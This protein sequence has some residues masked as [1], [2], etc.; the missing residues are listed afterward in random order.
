MESTDRATDT[1]RAYSWFPMIGRIIEIA[2]PG[3]HL[4]K[5]R[6]SLSVEAPTQP[7]QTIPLDTLDAVILHN[8]T[9]LSVASINA[10]LDVGAIVVFCNDKYYPAALAFPFEGH[11]IQAE[12]MRLQLSASQPLRKRLWQAIVQEKI[13][14]QSAL[15]ERTVQS[16]A[17]RSFPGRVQ[18]GDSEN[19]EAQAAR[20]YWRELFGPDFRRGRF[21]D[22]E[23]SLLNYGYAVL[24]ATTARAVASSGLHPSFALHHRD[25]R[26]AMALVDDIM[27][28]Y[29]PT[30]DL[31][32]HDISRQGRGLDSEAKA[33]LASIIVTDIHTDTGLSPLRNCVLRTAS[34]LIKAFERKEPDIWYPTS[35]LS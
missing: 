28:P 11:H 25:A 1:A 9:T 5:I 27:E 15:L 17:L 7:A 4:R 34:S 16:H 6:G 24:R 33:A 32:A 10:L 35:V 22:P 18:S 3:T 20:V 31:I 29:R 23:N 30:T 8:D 2:T 12:R 13:Q 19:I 26:N 21:T 14:Q